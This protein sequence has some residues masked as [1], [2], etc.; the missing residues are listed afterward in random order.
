M[1]FGDIAMSLEKEGTNHNIGGY[2]EIEKLNYDEFNKIFY[3][4]AVLQL[5]KLRQIRKRILGVYY[6]KD[7]D[8]NLAKQQIIKC[9]EKLTNENQVRD[10]LSNLISEDMDIK[11]PPWEFYL[12]ED[13]SQKSSMLITRMHHSF[14]DGAG[15]VSLMSFLNDEKFIAKNTKS[16]PKYG[17][18]IVIL[19]WILTPIFSIYVLLSTKSFKTD[20][21]AAKIREVNEEENHKPKFLS[22]EEISFDSIRKCYKKHNGATF[23]DYVLATLSTSL[24]DWYKKNNINGASHINISLPV[25][26]RSLP[27]S[28]KDLKLDN[29]SVIIKLQFPIW[30]DFKDCLSQVRP[31]IRKYLKP[32]LLAGLINL[33]KI[34]QFFPEVAFRYIL[35]DFF[36]GIDM[37]FSNVPFSEEPFYFLNKQVLNF[38]AFSNL[39]IELNVFLVCI[40]YRKMVKFSLI[41]K[42]NL[43]MDPQDLLDNI[44]NKIKEDISHTD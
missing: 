41:T 19:Q 4:R 38:W 32:N 34:F 8:A 14:T 26:F 2:F 29:N 42:E 15:F 9:K 35:N 33:G 16:I 37:C 39:M 3:E 1:G 40:T 21:I 20:N 43:K 31:G 18:F 22:A 28:I 36:G 17:I 11:L 25:N 6:W 23:N 5:R 10:Y 24:N 27:T 13:Y 44:V 12:I 30:N 7:V